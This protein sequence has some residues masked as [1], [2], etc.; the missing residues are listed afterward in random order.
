MKDYFVLTPQLIV[1]GAINSVKF[2]L[3]QWKILLIFLALGLAI[4]YFLDSRKPQHT[5]YIASIIFNVNNPAAQQQNPMMMMGDLGGLLGMGNATNANL[6]AG[7]N[8]LFMSRS[9]PVLQRA[10]L[11]EVT[12]GD[13]KDLFVNYYMDSSFVEQ[14][15][16]LREDP[17]YKRTRFKVNKREL[18]T[19]KEK[20]VFDRVLLDIL[21]ETE[22]AQLDVKTTLQQLKT[23]MSNEM[24]S[25]TW[26]ETLLKTI[27]TVYQ[28]NNNQ[29]SNQM[30]RMMERRA[31]SLARIL[32]RT[33][34]RLAYVTDLNQ[35]AVGISGQVESAR[36]TRNTGYI[37][38]LYLEASKSLENLKVSI[39][40]ET[41]LFKVVEPAQLP[42]DVKYY[43]PERSIFGT[44]I[45]LLVG[46]VFI[47][48]RQAYLQAMKEQKD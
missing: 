46:C 35:Q 39:I 11:S 47:F 29:K 20:F 13:H 8:F 12:V 42:L 44:L 23:T 15:A 25:K 5:G 24:L 38:G 2:I 33:E 45:G 1:T 10:M 9:K 16:L 37:T 22:V 6:F 3:K 7:E 28:E 21:F 30:L 19:K 14:D 40:R 43:L 41:P 18:M 48:F 4:G 31:D 36:L 26:A 27:E 17:E 32:N 34:N